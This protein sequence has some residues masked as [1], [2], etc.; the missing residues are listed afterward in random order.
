MM[1]FYIIAS[2]WFAFFR[3][4]YVRRGDQFTMPWPRPWGTEPG[5]TILPWRR[6]WAAQD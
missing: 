6:S 4:R 3:Y 5:A 1:A 2:L